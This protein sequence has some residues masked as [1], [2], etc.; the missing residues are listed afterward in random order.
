MSKLTVVHI[1]EAV[2]FGGHPD[3]LTA[4]TRS[5]RRAAHRRLK[6]IVRSLRR[7]RLT[8]SK[9]ARRWLDSRIHANEAAVECLRL[10]LSQDLTH[11]N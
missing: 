3:Q 9:P 1:A 7:D 5:T 4:F 6:T 8:A 2:A 10:S 11:A